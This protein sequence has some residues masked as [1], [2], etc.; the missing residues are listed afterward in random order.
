MKRMIL[1]RFIF[2]LSALTA[3]AETVLW[4][5]DFNND[6]AGKPPLTEPY[7]AASP[8]SIHN[9]CCPG[10][11]LVLGA[12]A[13]GGL[14]DKPVKLVKGEATPRT[15]AIRFGEQRDIATTGIVRFEWDAVVDTF[16]PSATFGGS[17]AL[18]TLNLYDNSGAVFFFTD[19]IVT[20]PAG[21]GIFGCIGQSPRTGSW[22]LGVTESFHPRRES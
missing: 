2:V 18:L 20:Q 6:S 14:T 21:G 4:E 7:R 10:R 16:Q 5:V 9:H 22:K 3:Q 1:S 8:V 11:N 12:A 15:P 13:V 17:E 19:Y